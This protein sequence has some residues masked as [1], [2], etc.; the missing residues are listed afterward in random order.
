LPRL[1]WLQAEVIESD[2][3]E[4]GAREHLM[5]ELKAESGRTQ[6]RIETMY[7][8]RLDGQISTEFFDAKSAEWRE[9]KRAV[10]AAL[11]QNAT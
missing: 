7:M 9:Q 2:K 10:A 1:S 6:K 8:D 4:A 11:M 3:T 5:Q